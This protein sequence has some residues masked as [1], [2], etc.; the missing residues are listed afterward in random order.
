MAAAAADMP[1]RGRLYVSVKDSGCGMRQDD[2]RK[3]FKDFT[4]LK[5]NAHLNPN[6]V[7]LGLS[8]CKKICKLMDGD[9]N[10][11]SKLGVGSTFTFFVACDIIDHSIGTL[12]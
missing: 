10:I 5:S 12:K 11:E 3:L 6:G 7:G 1:T 2:Q 4:T 8:I 9:I